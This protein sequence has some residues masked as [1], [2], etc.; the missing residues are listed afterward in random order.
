[1]RFTDGPFIEMKEL[2]RTIGSAVADA[3]QQQDGPATP[4]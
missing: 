1:V 4:H 3:I 2:N